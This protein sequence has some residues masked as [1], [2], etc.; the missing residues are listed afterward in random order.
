MKSRFLLLPVL[1]TTLFTSCNP[2]DTRIAINMECVYQVSTL[3]A[4][5]AGYYYGVSTVGDVLA[6]GNIG[7]GTFDGA[8]GEMIVLDGLCYKASYDGT[9]ELQGRDTPVPFASTTWFEPDITANFTTTLD[10]EAL[11]AEL[12]KIVQKNGANTFYV[13]RME[14]SFPD[15]KVRAISKQEEPYLPLDKVTETCQYVY[16]YKNL[17]GTLIALYCPPYVTGVNAVGWHLHFLSS[18]KSKGGHVLGLTMSHGS[19]AMDRTDFFQMELP[20]TD[21]FNSLNLLGQED[22]IDKVEKGK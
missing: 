2:P 5:V 4:L 12:D 17:E 8:D 13:M 7:L 9:V 18:D 11:K 19:M 10:M 6:H 16:D 14:G 22:A 1:V 21:K 20:N 3:Q 15:M